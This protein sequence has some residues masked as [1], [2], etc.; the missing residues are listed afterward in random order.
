MAEEIHSALMTPPREQ[1]APRIYYFHP[2]L[3][4]PRVTWSQHLERCQGMGF[5]HV[6][7]APIFASDGDIF[8]T[9]DYDRVHSAIGVSLST[10]ELVQQFGAACRENGLRLL[11]DVMLGQMAPGAELAKSAANWFHVADPNGRQVDPRQPRRYSA[12][13]PRFDDP[14]VAKQIEGWWSERLLRLAGA[15]V[16]GF[17]CLEPQLVPARVWRNVIGAV[18]R[19]FPDCRFLAWTPGLDWQDIACLRGTGFTASF[20]SLPWWDERAS[21]YAEEHELL[22]GIGAVIAYPEAPFGPRLARRYEDAASLPAAY[23]HMLRCAAATGNGIMV[24]MGFEFAASEDMDR[25]DAISAEFSAVQVGGNCDVTADIRDANALSRHLAELGI[26]GEMRAL[27]SPESPVTAFVRSDAPDIRQAQAPIVVLINSDLQRDQAVPISLDPLPP[28]AGAGLAVAEA[29]SADRDSHPSLASGE[30]RVLRARRSAP[31]KLRRAEV[32]SAKLAAMPRVVIENVVPSVDAGRFAAKRVIGEAVTVEADAFSDGHEV[33]VVELLW[34]AG[35][36]S[37]WRRAPMQ[38]L[39][40]DRWRTT[41]LPDRI[42]R[43]EFTVAAWVDRYASLCRD[44]EIKRADGADIAVEIAEGRQLLEL[45]Q[46]RAAGTER[47]IVTSALHWLGDACTESSADILLA[48][49]LR[50]LMVEIEERRFEV[51]REPAFPLDVERPQAGFAAWYELFPRSQTDTSSRHG[52]FDDVIRRLPALQDMGFDVLYLPPIHPI[53]TTN[54]KGKNNSLHAAPS[55]VGSPY[56]IGGGEGGHDSIHP[57]LGGFDGFRRLRDAAA[58]HGMELALDFAIQCSPDHPWLK[59][60]PEW[61][62]WRADGSVRYAENPPKKYEDIVNV[63]FYA[64]AAMPDLWIALRDIVLFWAKE[65]VRIFRVDNPHTKPLPFWEWLIAQVR[66]RYPEV[67]FLAEAFTR[68]KMMYRLAKVGFS[69]SYTYFTWRN[70]K[71]EIT[72]YF[73]ELTTSEAKEF[74]R[75]HLF[76]NTPDINPYFLQTSGRP[77]FLIRA[78]LAATLSGLWGMYSGFELCEATPL[79][80]REEY[81]DSEKYEIRVRR[82]DAPG[83]IIAEISKLN[84]IRKSN[85]ALQTQAGLRFYPAHNDH[86]VFYGKPLPARGSMILVAVSLDPVHAQE[87][88]IEVPVWEWNLADNA[89]VTVDDLMRGT[90]F[91]WAGK[92]Q[93]IRLDPADLPF[94]IWR[95]TP[96]AGP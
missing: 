7:M 63:D 54:R 48:P 13:Y 9:A 78:A 93:R 70:T 3:A 81:L 79:P 27:T 30:V 59:E 31:I 73:T 61:F 2:L 11:L 36:E 26:A 86:I 14:G 83:N 60:H 87:A 42:G 68:P 32:R 38:S 47:K 8:L 4:G 52:T 39:G 17:R 21:W 74:F 91:V 76:V 67:I 23:R 64:K 46:E 75:P 34:R 44:L 19:S 65:G 6:L 84:R 37:D 62:N 10:D 12:A 20:S 96:A 25:G 49:D 92:S 45:A 16:A 22:R 85:P 43:H 35:D 28:S 82:Y 94:A 71:Q 5:D 88:T 56:A 33:L 58:D 69:Q 1:F 66:V 51:R 50:E 55:D 80:G 41:I 18:A 29:V 24:P 53:G 90:S 95:V 77:G 57:A 72:D 89:A 15:G 40:N